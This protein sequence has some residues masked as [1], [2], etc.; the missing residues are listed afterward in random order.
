VGST[1]SVSPAGPLV[2][3]LSVPGDKSISHRALFMAAMAKGRTVI[4]GLGDGADVRSTA[5]AMVRLGVELSP[6]GPLVTADSPGWAGLSEPEDII[7]AGNSGTTTRLLAG[8]VAS[9]PF[10][11][12]ITGDRSLQ[13]RPMARVAEPL[14][15]MGARVS[16]RLGGSALPLSI[17]GAA[18]KAVDWALPVASAQVKTALILAALGAAGTSTITEPRA[19]RDHTERLLAAFGGE[20][21]RREMTSGVAL[22][23]RGGQVLRPADVRVPGDPSS[24]AFFLA[25]AAV[26]DGS[27]VTVEGVGLNPTRTAF[28]DVLLAMGAGVTVQPDP[29]GV[30]AAEPYG[31]IRVRG[32]SRLRG[33][34]F[35]PSL[36]PQLIDEVPVLAVVA[37]LAEGRTVVSGAAELRHKESD[38]IEGTARLVRLA[39]GRAEVTPDGLVI[40]GRGA[41]DGLEVFDCSGDHRLAMAAAVA[42]IG[43]NRRVT[44]TGADAAGVSYPGFWAD[45][46]SL[47]ARVQTEPGEQRSEP[48]EQR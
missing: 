27:D 16:G 39:G 28:I 19:T 31:S 5:A 33:V 4:R 41:V 13:A 35:D 43:S 15:A 45:L 47:G 3:R 20:V 30:R 24:A 36:I 12:V 1:V 21:E 46:A 2:G 10:H 23:V 40:E 38:R 37:A 48:G 14:R 7:D 8:L 18:L 42:A 32:S 9:R 29:T 17:D 22:I 11:T 6:L 44:I 34:T 26:V 25:A